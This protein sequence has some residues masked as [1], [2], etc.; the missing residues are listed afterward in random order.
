MMIPDVTD[1]N[2][3]HRLQEQNGGPEAHSFYLP[4][5]NCRSEETITGPSSFTVAYVDKQT[6]HDTMK[7]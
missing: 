3:L 7:P 4:G 1:M 2:N 5:V 6:Q